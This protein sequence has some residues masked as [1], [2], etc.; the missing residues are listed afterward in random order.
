[1]KI[2]FI[3]CGKMGGALLSGL[4]K[5]GVCRAE[6]VRVAEHSEASL[7]AIASLG[8]A[9][10]KSAAEAARASDVV[11][12]CVKPNDAEAALTDAREALRGKL[13]ISILAGVKL[14]TLQKFAGDSVRIA[15]VMPNVAALI[16]HGMSGFA[17]SESATE[18]DVATIEKI[19]GAVGEVARVE[20]ESQI[21]VVTA[22]SG[23][24]PA[25]V[26]TIIEALA[27][28]GVQMGLPR[29]LA[30][31]LAAKTLAGAAEMALQ[32]GEHPAKLRDQ[33]TSPG[34]TTIA[35]LEA[36]EKNRLRFALMSAVRA[37]AERA[38]ELGA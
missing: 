15:R 38:K 23:S 10:S 4:L 24:G 1:M 35:G 11:L 32:T 17:V 3:G 27:D 12:L 2:G 37:A 16:G 29:D 31:K 25:Y 8:V 30:Q 21:D 34:G 7:T 13:L 6:D 26:F 5:S 19:F 9:I 28:G 18:Q 20:K 33:V 22:I 36:L 14:A